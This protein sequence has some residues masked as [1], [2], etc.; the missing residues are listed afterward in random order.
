MSHPNTALITGAF[1]GIGAV[2][3]DRRDA[4]AG[5]RSREDPVIASETA[6]PTLFTSM[7]VGPNLSLAHAAGRF[8]RAGDAA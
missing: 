1:A 5:R 7:A 8:K 2:Y 3:A 6:T 4:L